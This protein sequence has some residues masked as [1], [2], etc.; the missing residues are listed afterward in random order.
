MYTSS[1]HVYMRPLEYPGNEDAEKL[2]SVASEHN[3]SQIDVIMLIDS[4]NVGGNEVNCHL[5]EEIGRYDFKMMEKNLKLK[6]KRKGKMSD[7]CV[8]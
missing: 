1:E 5:S 3:P 2:L 4:R 6:F 7:T 8:Y